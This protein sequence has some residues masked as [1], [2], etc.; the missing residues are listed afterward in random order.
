MWT[1]SLSFSSPQTQAFRTGVAAITLLGEVASIPLHAQVYMHTNGLAL[2]KLDLSFMTT[3]FGLLY[4]SKSLYGLWYNIYIIIF[5]SYILYILY[6]YYCFLLHYIRCAHVIV[7]P[8]GKEIVIRPSRKWKIKMHVHMYVGSWYSYIIIIIW[9]EC[10]LNSI[11]SLAK[12]QIEG[13]W[14]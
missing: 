8:Y 1:S 10:L 7:Y 2:M 13:H 6:L 12:D 3:R 14:Q 5:I 4:F 11:F 9:C